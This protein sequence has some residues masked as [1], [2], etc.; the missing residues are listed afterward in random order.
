MQATLALLADT[1]LE[2]LSTR[3][4]AKRVG[5]SQPALFRH[6]RSRDAI[7]AAVINNM[8]ARIADDAAGLL[9]ATT[10]PLARAAGLIALLFDHATHFP[11]FVRLVLAESVRAEAPSY[12]GALDQLLGMQQSFFAAFVR[13][14][15][16]RG[17][18]PEDI[19]DSLAARLLV[20]LVQGTLLSWMRQGRTTSLDAW[21]APV[22]E[23]W[24]AGLRAQC[25]ALR[26]AADTAPRADTQRRLIGLDVRPILAGGEDPL[27]RILE[28]L[29]QLRGDGVALVVA[30]FRPAPLLRLLQEKG[31]RVSVQE[32]GDQ[33]FQVTVLGPDARA[34][35]DLSDLEAPLPLERVLEQAAALEPGRAAHFCVP[36]VPR[37]LLP[38]LAERDV[39]HEVLAQVDGRAVLAI[40]RAE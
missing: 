10:E 2:R 39:R 35:V 37:L 22:A 13:D 1:P 32:L 26:V 4:I 29:S 8:R 18:M 19:D 12:Q 30:P 27:R 17:Q 7:V 15:Q 33:R 38:R 20:S 34:V 36:R 3:Q 24:L 14:A 25:P 21:V 6:F 31:Y 40:W 23:L 9:E 5:V 16:D 11:G 28:T